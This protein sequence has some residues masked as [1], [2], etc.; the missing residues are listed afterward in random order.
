MD[1]RTLRAEENRRKVARAMLDL[2]REGMLQP[3]REQVAERARLSLRSV[4]HHYGNLEDLYQETC[5]I[6][7]ASIHHLVNDLPQATDES[8]PARVEAFVT[9]RVELY[10]RIAP[11]RRSA[12][13]WVH[14][15][16]TLAQGLAGLSETMRKQLAGTFEAELQGLDEPR[17]E[18]L[19]DTL[20]MTTSWEA[21]DFLLER[22]GFPVERVRRALGAAM[23]SL[24]ETRT[25]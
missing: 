12:M 2:I 13:I 24:L 5:R 20:E 7:F 10:E 8:L 9:L 6:Q 3:T 21:W 11:V 4:Y 17:R 23:M 22:K 14:R 18:T 15:S 1:G 25:S 16:P 19:L